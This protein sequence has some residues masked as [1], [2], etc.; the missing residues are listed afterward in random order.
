MKRPKNQTVPSADYAESDGQQM[1]RLK[2][3]LSAQ[4]HIGTKLYDQLRRGEC[5]REATGADLQCLADYFALLRPCQ[6][7][8]WE[9]RYDS[10]TA[11]QTVF[12]I[13]QDDQH[14]D[15]ETIARIL[16]VSLV[17]VRVTR[18]RLRSRERAGG[19]PPAPSEP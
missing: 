4:L 5:I 16:G 13:L 19:Q 7:H 14:C 10:L 6:Y 11:R 2:Q 3:Q 15:D 9:Q 1:K 12:L 18:S 17:A 8:L